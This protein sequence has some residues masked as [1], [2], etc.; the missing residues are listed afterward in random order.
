MNY[1][2]M[3]GALLILFLVVTLN[4]DAQYVTNHIK[5]VKPEQTEGVY[6]YLPRNVVRI[7][8]EVEQIQEVKGQYADYAKELLN[9]DNYI[10]NNRVKYS[11]KNLTINTLTEPDPD[12]FFFVSP[13]DKAKEPPVFNFN[14][15]G[16]GII[17]SFG[18]DF[19]DYMQ[20]VNE[21]ISNDI[22]KLKEISEYHYIPL[23][24]DD[25]DDDDID[26][27]S[28]DEDED[29]AKPSPK[30]TS[31][32][33]M[34]EEEIAE[35]IIEEIKKIRTLYVDLMTGYQEVNYGTTLNYMAEQLRNIE[36]EYLSEFLGKKST[37]TFIKTFYILPEAGNNSILLGKFS[38]NEGFDSK[39]GESLK[40]NF[41]VL[42]SNSNMN[43]LSVD[44]VE[45]T[46]YY[47]KLFYRNPAQVSVQITH[48]NNLLLD[49][50][51]VISQLGNVLLVPMNKMKIIFDT[52]TGQVLS[53][54]KE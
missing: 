49:N 47:N 31:D 41:Q 34:T 43:R 20:V 53:V 48:G 5:N 17:K 42:S 46:S 30:D 13:D 7:D 50:K 45:K 44:A 2:K 32:N 27:E 29:E 3:R 24:S 10:K 25:E 51:L 21:T 12:M 33:K 16:D 15:T 14:M 6:Y 1:S 28:D 54:V 35:S 38:E 39:S 26:M 4:L 11:I 52:N 18:H 40:V 9:T 8:V 23:S 19:G 22:N 36:K 37:S